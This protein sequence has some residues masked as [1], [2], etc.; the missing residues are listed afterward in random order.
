M[1]LH[2]PMSEALRLLSSDPYASNQGQT[3]FLFSDEGKGI[4]S[5][6]SSC[7]SCKYLLTAHCFQTRPAEE[8]GGRGAEAIQWQNDCRSVEAQLDQTAELF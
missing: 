1:R 7:D 2:S 4:R 6:L 5:S 3:T 8:E